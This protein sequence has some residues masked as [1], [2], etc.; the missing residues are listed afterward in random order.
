MRFLCFFFRLFA[1]R[2]PIIVW[3]N[4][5]LVQI[6]FFSAADTIL[7]ETDLQRT[8]GCIFG[9]LDQ[10]STLVVGRSESDRLPRRHINMEADNDVK[11]QKNESPL[12]TTICWSIVYTLYFIHHLLLK[13]SS[14]LSSRECFIAIFN[15][16]P[17]HPA[18]HPMGPPKLGFHLS[19][20]PAP[21]FRNSKSVEAQKIHQ[22]GTM[23]SNVVVFLNV[24]WM[25][26]GNNFPLNFG[27]GFNLAVF[28]LNDSNNPST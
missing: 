3:M 23:P 11:S 27:C 20:R 19:S 21:I 24:F 5:S 22:P 8:P 25:G 18:P 26:E 12:L 16:F 15:T 13:Y 14:N 1:I 2:R 10:V 6:F 4:Q 7:P 9:E 17:P 28:F